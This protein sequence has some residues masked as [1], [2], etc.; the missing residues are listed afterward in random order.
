MAVTYFFAGVERH[1]FLFSNAI[2]D[3][4]SFVNLNC[5]WSQSVFPDMFCNFHHI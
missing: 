4:L 3:I 1:E 5:E 2:R